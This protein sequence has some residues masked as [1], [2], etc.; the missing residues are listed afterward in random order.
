[1]KDLGQEVCAAV[2]SGLLAEPFD[3]TTMRSACP[4]W[5]ESAYHIFLS[6]HAVGVGNPS[7]LVERVSFRLYRLKRCSPDV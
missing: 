6:E 2:E 4:G 3:A 7:E 1:M 5:T